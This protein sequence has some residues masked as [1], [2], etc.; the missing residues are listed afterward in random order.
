LQP[1]LQDRET[2]S[3]EGI[4][5]IIKMCDRKQL[6]SMGKLWPGMISTFVTILSSTLFKVSCADERVLQI[7]KNMENERKL[8]KE[9]SLA[10]LDF[11]GEYLGTLNTIG[12]PSKAAIR[13]GRLIDNLRSLKDNMEELWE[14]QFANLQ[15]QEE[16]RGKKVICALPGYV[17][18]PSG[19]PGCV[20]KKDCFKFDL[21][22][23]TSEECQSPSEREFACVC[24]E[25]Y[26]RD[27]T[28]FSGCK[29]DETPPTNNGGVSCSGK[30]TMKP[31]CNVSCNGPKKIHVHGSATDSFVTTTIVAAQGAESIQCPSPGFIDPLIVDCR[32]NYPD[33]ICELGVGCPTQEFYFRLDCEGDC[34]NFAINSLDAYVELQDCK[35]W[36]P[37]TAACGT[38][39]DPVS[40]C[41][42]D[43]SIVL[44][45]KS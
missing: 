30:V 44:L 21:C 23:T 5:M 10:V 12:L 34:E 20:D 40:S 24:K 33:E 1:L 15:D 43:N 28:L 9:R 13:L 36:V 26:V 4:M 18:D 19:G 45:F 7:I 37:G 8:A 16:A 22:D 14:T 39:E 3:A 29:S 6:R 32:I 27:E 17:R 31:I 35:L 41:S 38:M 25:G 42:T 11:Y 2:Q